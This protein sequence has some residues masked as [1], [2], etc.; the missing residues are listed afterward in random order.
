MY[1]K[2]I[3]AAVFSAVTAASA[4]AQQSTT[5]AQIPGFYNT[6]THQFTPRINNALSDTS[7]TTK[8]TGTLKFEF[9]IDLLKPVPSGYVVV[10]SVSAYLFDNNYANTFSFS[11]YVAATVNGS[12]GTCTAS[13]PYAIPLA[14]ADADSFSPNYL[15]YLVPASEPSIPPD[16]QFP[17]AIGILANI[18]VPASGKTTTVSN[19]VAF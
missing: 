6:R 10:C 13:V 4:F 8:Y 7:D 5:P 19:D 9:K 18:N 2:L 14:T 3:L 11:S 16:F 15:I 17:Y 1:R 12:V